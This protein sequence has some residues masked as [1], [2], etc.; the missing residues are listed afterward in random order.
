M[1]L[2]GKVVPVPKKVQKKTPPFLSQWKVLGEGVSDRNIKVFL[3]FFCFLLDFSVF[4]ICCYI[5][6]SKHPTDQTFHSSRNGGFFFGLF[7]DHLSDERHIQ[8]HLLHSP[9][10]A[11]KFGGFGGSKLCHTDYTHLSFFLVKML[12]YIHIF[13]GFLGRNATIYTHFGVSWESKCFHH[14][15]IS[16]I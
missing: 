7:R 9:P 10:Q 6:R 15:H 5:V 13:V 11:K 12:P 8:V 1:T 4:L 3:I 2:A 16:G 14:I